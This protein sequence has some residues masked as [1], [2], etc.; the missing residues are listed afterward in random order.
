MVNFTLFT[1]LLTAS[2]VA[3]VE[4]ASYNMLAFIQFSMIQGIDMG[5]YL[6]IKDG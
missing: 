1:S 3:I 2:D 6:R 4:A 5:N